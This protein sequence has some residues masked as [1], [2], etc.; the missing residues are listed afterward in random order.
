MLADL[1]TPETVA[2]RPSGDPRNRGLVLARPT[3]F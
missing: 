1:T 3:Q 2:A